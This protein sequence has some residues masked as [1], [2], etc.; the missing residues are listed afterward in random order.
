MTHKPNSA[1]IRYQI[2]DMYSAIQLQRM[3]APDLYSDSYYRAWLQIMGLE[4]TLEIYH[5]R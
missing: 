3:D 4:D 5:D 2:A 1:K